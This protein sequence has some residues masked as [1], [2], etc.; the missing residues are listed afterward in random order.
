[1][2]TAGEI[3][4]EIL[5]RDGVSQSDLAEMME[6]DRRAIHQTL[7]KNQDIKYGKFVEMLDKLGYKITIEKK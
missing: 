7:R 1:M 5:E 3:I 4:E 6:E 2:K